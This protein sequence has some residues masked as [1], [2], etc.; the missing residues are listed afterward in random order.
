M[1]LA[2]VYLSVHTPRYCT[3]DAAFAG[4]LAHPDFQ[5]VRDGLV[6]QGRHVATIATKLAAR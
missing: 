6:A 4:K 2:G 1:G 3:Y 5:T